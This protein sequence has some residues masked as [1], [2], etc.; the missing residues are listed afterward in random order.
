MQFEKKKKLDK[1]IFLKCRIIINPIDLDQ[2]FP[3]KPSEFE[4]S[5]LVKSYDKEITENH[6]NYFD[7]YTHLVPN[8]QRY[9]SQI[10]VA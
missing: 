2:I 3:M 8:Y 4:I 5:L 6:Q 7:V 9:R 1:T 10:L